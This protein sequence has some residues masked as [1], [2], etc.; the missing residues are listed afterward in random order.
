MSKEKIFER[1]RNL[2]RLSESD[3]PHEAELALKRA[4][5]MMKEYCVEEHEL[6]INPELNLYLAL[7]I[8]FIDE[9]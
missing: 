3:N 2:L 4:N 6:K 8:D 7:K 1:I 5:E 9:N